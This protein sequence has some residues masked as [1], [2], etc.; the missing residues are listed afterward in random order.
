MPHSSGGGSH[1]G[2]SHHSS[3]HSSHHSS[4]GGS[5]G[6]RISSSYFTGSH[7]YVYYVN[8]RPKYYYS[9]EKASDKVASVRATVLFVLI[10]NLIWWAITSP[11]WTQSI[12]VPKKLTPPTG[13]M[14]EIEDSIGILSTQ[15]EDELYEVFE[16]FQ[17][18]TGITVCFL[19]LTNSDWQEHYFSLEN[20]AYD[21]YVTY[22]PDETYWLLT[23]SS[24]LNPE[25]ED[26]HWEGMQGDDTDNILTSD[27][28][29]RFTEDVQKYLLQRNTY[30]VAEALEKAFENLSEGIMDTS[31]NAFAFFPIFVFNMF[32]AIISIVMA[33]QNIE[34][35]RRKNSVICASL[36]APQED[37]CEYCRGIYVHG[38]HLSCPH[39][40]API[41]PQES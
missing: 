15:E 23:Y 35:N 16:E 4:G 36:E 6:P 31:F 7:R 38:L 9:T 37:T 19:S 5:S 20:F 28:A 40:G 32:P 34:A 30:T 12:H 2:G 14:P 21:Y 22:Y 24:D 25:F 18:K 29:N 10:F 13:A 27:K 17:R 3:S 1:G 39:C 41:K 26:W 8:K 33:L 11:F